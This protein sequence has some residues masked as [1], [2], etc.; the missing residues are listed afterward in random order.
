MDRL[1]ANKKAK[2]DKKEFDKKYKKHNDKNLKLMGELVKYIRKLN[3]EKLMKLWTKYSVSNAINRVMSVTQSFAISSMGNL[4]E[5][6]FASF[7]YEC[8]KCGLSLVPDGNY[9]KKGEIKIIKNQFVC[10]E[11][12]KKYNLVEVKK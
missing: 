11:C 1:D 12:G 8:L 2:K 10:L 3:D 5:K 4:M 9:N 6:S 7:S